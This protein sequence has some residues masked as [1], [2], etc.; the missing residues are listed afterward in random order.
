M[1]C[2]SDQKRLT[3]NLRTIAALPPVI[4]VPTTHT[5]IALKWNSGSGVSTM[6]SARALPRPGDLLGERDDVV[7]REHAALRRPGG[8]GGVD[9]AGQIRRPDAGVGRRRVGPGGEQR[10]PVVGADTR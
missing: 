1:R 10:L 6:S 2:T 9:E 8:A 4:S 3:E 5:E 7:L